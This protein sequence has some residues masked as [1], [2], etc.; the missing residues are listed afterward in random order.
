MIEEANSLSTGLV[1]EF[2]R[3]LEESHLS[4][5]QMSVKDLVNHTRSALRNEFALVHQKKEQEIIKEAQEQ[6]EKEKDEEENESESS[7]T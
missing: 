4:L 7:Q 6:F 5:K 3:A 1:D 2:K